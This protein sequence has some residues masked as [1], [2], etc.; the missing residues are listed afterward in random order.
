ML[1]IL[2]RRIE[3]RSES[4]LFNKILLDNQNNKKM[5]LSFKI[6]M[7]IQYREMRYISKKF[8]R[9]V[10]NDHLLTFNTSILSAATYFIVL[11]MADIQYACG[12]A[13]A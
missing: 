6:V 4:V 10:G 8:S 13:H 5:H 7:D 9:N 12:I 3:T 2:V 11:Y 1:W